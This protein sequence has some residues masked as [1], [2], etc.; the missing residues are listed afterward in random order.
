VG[1][2]A[3]LDFSRREKSTCRYTNACRHTD[4]AVFVRE[5]RSAKWNVGTSSAFVV[6]PRKT[7]VNT[8]CQVEC[9][10]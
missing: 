4:Y 7:A 5:T 3:G 9:G 6:G 8:Q 1:S 2:I 10:N